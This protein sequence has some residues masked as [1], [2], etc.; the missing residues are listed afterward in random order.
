MAVKE[1]LNNVKRHA[2][3]TEIEYRMAMVDNKLEIIIADN[4]KG[5][6]GTPAGGGY[7]LKNLSG[8]LQKLGGRCVVE[9]RPGGG[10]MVQ[11]WLPLTAAT[12]TGHAAQQ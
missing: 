5:F 8:R 9:P 12:E 4:G 2:N 1:A 6:E 3:A 10:T 7:G 11:I